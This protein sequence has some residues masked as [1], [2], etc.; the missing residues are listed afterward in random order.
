MTLRRYIFIL[1]T[2]IAELLRFDFASSDSNWAEYK[3]IGLSCY[4]RAIGS[5]S[6]VLS[7][8]G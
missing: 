7:G 4:C 6:I 1:A 5:Q 2:E 8:D 3:P